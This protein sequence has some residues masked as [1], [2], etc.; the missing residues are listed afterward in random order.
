MQTLEIEKSKQINYI[1][2]NFGAYLDKLL[3]LQEKQKNNTSNKIVYIFYGLEKLKT[4]IDST[5]KLEKLF[6]S[7]KRSENTRLIICDSGKALKSLDYD[8]WYSDIK[9]ATDG[10]WIG[11]GFADQQN[12]R[13]SKVTKEMSVNY[14]NN[15][16]WYI[17]ESSAELMKV[18][19]F[20]ETLNKGEDDD[21]E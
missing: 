4:K 15:Y 20:N 5:S 21:E 16:G 8:T 17:S 10:I 7:V 18:I 19:E 6:Q 3:E 11:R 9:N 12:F 13:I 14:A 2:E 1:N